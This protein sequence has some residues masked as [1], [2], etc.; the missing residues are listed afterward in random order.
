M[1]EQ[2][3]PEF[4][5]VSTFKKIAQQI[6]LTTKQTDYDDIMTPDELQNE[7]DVWNL[8][9]KKNMNSHIAIF[10]HYNEQ[11]LVFPLV[12][13]D[14]KQRDENSNPLVEKEENKKNRHGIDQFN[15]ENKKFL[16]THSMCTSPSANYYKPTDEPEP[17]DLT[18]LNIEAS[19][20]CLVSKIKFLC[21]KCSSPAVRLRTQKVISRSQNSFKKDNNRQ[22]KLS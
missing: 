5:E 1:S 13:D 11:F 19:V 22:V 15:S 10:P 21:G 17:W 2:D 20:M 3:Q 12:N 16:D 14:K 9:S 6:S 8:L 4:E 18:Q 7:T